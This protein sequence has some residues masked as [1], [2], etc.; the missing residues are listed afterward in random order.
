MVFFCSGA[1]PALH[2]KLLCK[3]HIFKAVPGASA[4]RSVPAKKY[5]FFYKML[6]IA[7]RAIP[8]RFNKKSY[9]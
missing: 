8:N 4:G 7:I 3:K 6:S 9:Q 1:I 2:F 5:S